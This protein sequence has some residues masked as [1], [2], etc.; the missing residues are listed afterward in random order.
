[1]LSQAQQ[2]ILKLKKENKLQN[3]TKVYMNFFGYDES[4]TILCEMCEDVAVDIHHLERRNK[5]KND[6]IENLIGVCRSCHIKAE[7]DR[8]FNMYAKIKHLENV[9][10]QV[11]SLIQLEKRLKEYENRTDKN[12]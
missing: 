2:T 11:Y 3:H 5:I 7:S 6:Y 9:C 1:L 12:K 10:V 8:C 4:S